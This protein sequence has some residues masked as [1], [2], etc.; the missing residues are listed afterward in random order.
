MAVIL[1]FLNKIF[2][3]ATIFTYYKFYL[4]QEVFR[5]SNLRQYSSLELQILGVF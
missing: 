2:G 3:F 5:F 1:N 4:K